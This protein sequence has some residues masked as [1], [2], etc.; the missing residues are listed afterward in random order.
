M[1][2]KSNKTWDHVSRKKYLGGFDILDADT[3]GGD[4]FRVGLLILF[5]FLPVQ[6]TKDK[7]MNKDTN[8]LRRI[9]TLLIFT[10]CSINTP[11]FHSLELCLY[12]IIR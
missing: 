8:E 6:S 9:V 2:W 4:H 10:K 1:C 11:N 3:K 7:T 5:V 12:F